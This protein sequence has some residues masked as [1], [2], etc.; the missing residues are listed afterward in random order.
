[1]ESGHFILIS[2]RYFQQ[3]AKIDG[4]GCEYKGLKWN[5]MKNNF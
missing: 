5:E 1:M 4:E 2:G 3:L